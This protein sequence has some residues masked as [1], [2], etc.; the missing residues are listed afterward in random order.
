M[1]CAVALIF[2]DGLFGPLNAS[3]STSLETGVKT[4]EAL[5][6][7]QTLYTCIAIGAFDISLT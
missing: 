7:K 1:L 4:S 5:Q 3:D 2:S 6:N